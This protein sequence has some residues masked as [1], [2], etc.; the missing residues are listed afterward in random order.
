MGT[1]EGNVDFEGYVQFNILNMGTLD[2]E[3]LPR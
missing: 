1:D 2:E 3:G